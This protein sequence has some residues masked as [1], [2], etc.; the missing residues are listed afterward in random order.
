MA[1][2]QRRTRDLY[3]S[4]FAPALGSGRALRTW[5]C[6]RALAA[7]GPVDMLYLP[8]GGELPSPEYAAI[9]GLTF[10]LVRSSRGLRRAAVYLDRR[11]RGVP[12]GAC[13]GVAPEL[14][15]EAERLAAEPGRGRVIVGDLV[16]ATALLDLARRRPVIYNA[17]NVEHERVGKL[18]QPLMRA[19][20]RRLLCTAAESWMV[21]RA[22]M[23]GAQALC[24]QARLRYVPNV[25]D[26]A[27]IRPRRDDRREGEG[28]LM[29]GDFT[30]AP[31]RSGRDY[32][33]ADVLPRV[34]REIPAARL[35]LVG[36]GLDG[37]RP[38]AA[39]V[40]VAG[41]VPDLA[42]AYAA[43]DCVVVPLVEGA[44]TP[45][46]F[47]E[48]MAYGMPVVA[49][50]RAARGLDVTDGVHFREGRDAA[51]FADAVV[52]VLRGGGAALGEAARRLAEREYSVETLEE[53]LAA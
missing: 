47:V 14:V 15:A 32:F 31:N 9:V 20:E 7:L 13:R 36:R 27:A 43:A 44:G 10:H 52:E 18:Q 42:A 53:R 8:H 2:E 41:F 30:Y 39:G 24:P 11:L 21:S 26:V 4:A 33:V 3:V 1:S 35:T 50:P 17:H 38:P 16:A 19:F 34:R 28:L 40:D 22:D 48:A 29:V 5:T 49:T 45:L 51:S 37:W 25:V 23:R 6:V 12:A 46:K